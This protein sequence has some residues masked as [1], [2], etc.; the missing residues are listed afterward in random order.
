MFNEY[1]SKS[2]PSNPKRD[3]EL[4]TVPMQLV[5]SQV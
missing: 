2:L 1:M 5:A 3:A 4:L